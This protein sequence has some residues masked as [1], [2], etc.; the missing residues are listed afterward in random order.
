MTK[1]QVNQLVL[2]LNKMKTLK[3]NNWVKNGVR[4]AESVADHTCSLALLSLLLAPP[5]LDRLKCLKMALVHDLPESYCGD[6]TAGELPANEKFRLEQTA[7][8]TIAKQFDLPELVSLFEEYE[9]AS[10]AE[11]KFLRALD[12]IDNVITAHLYEGQ[13]TGK[14]L[15]RECA[16][17][18]YPAIMNTEYS[19]SL[20]D[21]LHALF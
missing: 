5:E 9:A 20:L 8:N 11:A 19:A 7:I 10:T 14:N 16:S 1:E 6:F 21:I 3:R 13:A 2:I 4:R 12:K 15:V 18:A 17:D